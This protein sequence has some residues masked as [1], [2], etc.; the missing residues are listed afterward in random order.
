MQSRRRRPELPLEPAAL[1]QKQASQA[2]IKHSASD[3]RESRQ[4]FQPS[5]ATLCLAWLP[6]HRSVANTSAY[7]ATATSWWEKNLK[8]QD[9]P[10]ALSGLI[11]PETFFEA[12]IS[13]TALPPCW[14]PWWV[15]SPSALSYPPGQELCW[16]PACMVNAAAPLIRTQHPLRQGA[17]SPQL[18]SPCTEIKNQP[19]DVLVLQHLAVTARGTGSGLGILGV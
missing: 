3:T 7:P 10:S 13:Y 5:K 19:R 18:L 6:S 16:E 8:G 11:L 4:D 17:T 9:L 15:W 12:P 2:A 14:D 1:T